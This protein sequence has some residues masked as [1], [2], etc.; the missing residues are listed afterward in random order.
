MPPKVSVLM[1]NYNC[2]QYLAEAIESILNQSFTDFEFI[3]VDDC[4]TDHS[5]E[6]IQDYA[7]RDGRIVALRNEENLKICKTLNRGLEIAKWEYIAR[8]DSDDISMPERLGKQI[9]FLN[10][11]TDVW[12]I[13]TNCY[14]IDSNWI[15]WDEKK[16][17]ENNKSIKESIWVRNPFLHPS[18]IFKKECYKTLWWYNEDYIYA[19]DLELWIRYWKDYNVYNIQENLLA[20]RMFWLNA[21][22]QKQKLMIQNTLKVRKIAIKLWYKI[23]VKWRIHFFWTWCMQFLPP[24]FVLW[25]FNKII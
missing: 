7:K 19:E 18:V 13:W 23:S 11:N 15:K 22:L 8:M 16:Y 12:I 5:W 6:I 20:Y 9:D 3:I 2:E 17:P 1:P 25:L 24:R 10:T 14:F 4:S 21:T